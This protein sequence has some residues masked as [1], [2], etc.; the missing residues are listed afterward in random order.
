MHWNALLFWL[1]V[2]FTVAG[3]GGWWAAGEV[4]DWYRTLT[5]PAIAPPTWVY[6]PVWTLL[7]A[8]MAIAAWQVS[9]ADDSSLRTR[10]LVL[11]LVQ[12]ALNLAWSWIFFLEHDIGAAM[13]NVVVLWIAVGVTT[14]VF[15]RVTPVAALLMAPYWAW[16]TFATLLNA[17]LWRLNK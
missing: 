10:G 14:I 2:C 7:Y 9:L 6:G 13:A 4:T 12:L 15:G 1:G 16:V 3:I 11:F 5:K 8:L 17:A